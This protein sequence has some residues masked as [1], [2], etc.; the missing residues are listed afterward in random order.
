MTDLRVVAL[1]PARSGSEDVVRD[2]LSTLAQATLQHQGCLGYDLFE[3][4][5]A[6]GVFVT[7][8]TWSGQAD[9]DAHLQTDDVATAVAAATDHLA[10]DI[11][12][13]PLR[14]VER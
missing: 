10:G 3:S 13:H 1:V 2:V 4:A 6:P 14:P 11:A 5:A 8:E 7:V 9:L 12:V